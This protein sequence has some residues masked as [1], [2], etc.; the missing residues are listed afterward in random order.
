MRGIMRSLLRILPVRG[1][2]GPLTYLAIMGLL[3]LF[4]YAIDFM[5]GGVGNTEWTFLNCLASLVW[6]TVS[7]FLISQSPEGGQDFIR[8][9]LIL[10]VV[11]VCTVCRLRDARLGSMFVLLVFFPIYNLLLIGSLCFLGTR[12]GNGTI[13]GNGP[14]N[15]VLVSLLVSSIAGSLVTAGLVYMT[16]QVFLFGFFQWIGAPFLQGL[17]IAFLH[18]VTK[19]RT[20]AQSIGAALLG[21]VFCAVSLI[22][23][24]EY[25]IYSGHSDGNRFISDMEMLL[26]CFGVFYFPVGLLLVIGGALLGYVIPYRYWAGRKGENAVGPGGDDALPVSQEKAGSG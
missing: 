14:D 25:W 15:G 26:I 6:P 18:G 21:V 20:K 24:N 1:T 12:K 10:M 4:R 22:V 16:T 2:M 9:L 13:A 19:Q 3:L 17:V 5:V 11:L 23:L 8:G 7:T